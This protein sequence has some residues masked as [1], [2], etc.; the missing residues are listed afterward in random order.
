MTSVWWFFD[1]VHRCPA[2][3]LSLCFRN[4]K[5]K[6][7]LGLSATPTRADGKEQLIYA[8]IGP[9]RVESDVILKIPKV[10]V[11]HSD[12][13][14]PTVI[15]RN[16]MGKS[17]RVKMPHSPGKVGHI[18]VDL[19]KHVG[20]NEMIGKLAAMA[21]NKG[22]KTAIFCDLLDHVESI[23][24]ACRKAGIPREQMSQY[25]GGMSE[26]ARE[27]AKVKA[28]MV[29]TWGMF[30]EGTDVPWLDTAILAS[31]RSDV[32]Q[33][34]G[35]I[36]REYPDKKPELVIDIVDDDSPVFAGYYKRRYRWYRSI[37]AEIVSP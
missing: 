30:K 23:L 13:S 36:L 4:L 12:W 19:A 35:R 14:C 26:D 20:R 27:K 10:M 28:V 5:A 32:V 21:F 31:P 7:R 2:D 24:A 33:G 8:H 1:E 3:T 15:R 34:V 29:V 11:F 37:G 6:L 18:L 16:A 22:R 25:V 17:M 9:V